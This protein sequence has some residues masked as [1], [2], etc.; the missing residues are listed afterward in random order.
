MDRWSCRKEATVPLEA[1]TDLPASA[2]HP[3]LSPRGASAQRLTGCRS[4]E[5]LPLYLSPQYFFRS[6]VS[7]HVSHHSKYPLLVELLQ[8]LDTLL[9]LDLRAWS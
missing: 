5:S 4:L 7:T 6:S 3:A 8:V 2:A 1:V 9:F